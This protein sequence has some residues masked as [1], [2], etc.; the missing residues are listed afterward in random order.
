MAQPGPNNFLT[1]VIARPVGGGIVADNRFRRYRTVVRTSAVIGG[2]EDSRVTSIFYEVG[3]VFTTT[4]AALATAGDNAHL[5]ESSYPTNSVLVEDFVGL[6]KKYSNFSANFQYSSLAGIAERLAR[7]LAAA[8]LYDDVTSTSLRGNLPLAVQALATYDGPV[9]SLTD[10]V[11]IP[12]LVNSSLTGDV[13]AVLVN[14]VA[15]EGSSVAT[16]VIELD[17]NTRQPIIP[18]TDTVGTPGAIVD[19]LRIVGANM[20]A[21]DQGPLFALAVTRGIHK[22]LSVVGHSDEAGITRD[23]LRCG[24]FSSPFGGLHYGLEE[25]VGLPQL[26]YNNRSGTAAYCDAVALSTAALTSHAD[27]GIVYNDEWFPTFYDGTSTNDVT[28]R[29][30]DAIDGTAQHSARNRAQLLANQ[31]LFWAPYITGLG[32]IF[33]AVGNTSVAERFATGASYGLAADPRHLRYA[34]VAPWFWIEPT[35]LIPHDFLGSRAEEEGFGSYAYRD[36]QRSRPAWDRSALVGAR[37]TTFSAYHVK[38]KGARTSWFL[39]HWLGHPLNG[40]GATRVRQVDPNTIIHPGPC[41]GYDQIR[42]RVEADLPITDYLWTRGQSPFP[43]PGELLNLSSNW[44]ILFRHVTFSDD[45][46]LHP[47]HI[48]SAHELAD[49]VVTIQVGRPIGLSVGPS[50]HGDSGARRARTR[51]S[52]ELSAARKRTMIFGRA[53]VGEMPTATSAPGGITRPAYD[54]HRGGD[55]GGAGTTGNS[56]AAAPGHASASHRQPDGTALVATPHNQPLRFP[57]LPRQQG[58]IGGGAAPIPPVNPAGSGNP[59]DDD[60]SPPQP[61][62]I[63]GLPDD[64]PAAPGNGPTPE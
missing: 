4:G 7:G 55:N 59:P 58:G 9:N 50:N 41:A 19:A 39:A 23:L 45:G 56:R 61:P 20:V 57:V 2:S 62:V 3:R 22:V 44:G 11:Y 28:L 13:F 26:Q 31:Q 25:Y 38:M 6:A 17:A 49:C 54:S 5:V 12:R 53:D 63:T 24:G 29:P 15:G 43:A 52:I 10:T 42:D 30:G 18:E 14:A 40:L 16:D 34:S 1:G 64:P 32:R 48:P 46:D 21:S 27:P 60:N 33:G 35:G 36:T 47:E 37:D 8:S 51:A